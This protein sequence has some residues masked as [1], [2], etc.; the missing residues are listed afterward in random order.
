MANK[1]FILDGQ[2]ENQLIKYQGIE[3]SVEIRM[4]RNP[5]VNICLRQHRECEIQQSIDRLRL[6]HCNGKK[7]VFILTKLPLPNV[8]ITELMSLKKVVATVTGE[9]LPTT[10]NERIIAQTLNGNPG[11]LPFS[12]AVLHA[13]LP[14]EFKTAKSAERWRENL[15]KSIGFHNPHDVYRELCTGL[16]LLGVA[17]Y[18][19]SIRAGR[20]G[21]GKNQYCLSRHDEGTTQNILEKW[22][23]KTVVVKLSIHN[24]NDVKQP[25]I[26]QPLPVVEQPSRPS[27]FAQRALQRAFQSLIAQQALIEQQSKVAQPLIEQQALQRALIEQRSWMAQRALIE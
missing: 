12:V 21:G 9:P 20:N 13:L 16:G 22:H 14:E 5:Y 4:H 25:L 15:L 7:Q 10:R 24:H 19:Y 18:E 2:M 3:K 27:S 11:V 23:N 26:E 6:I 17:Y 1:D 8:E